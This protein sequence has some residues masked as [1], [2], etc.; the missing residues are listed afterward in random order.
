MKNI[1]LVVLLV[2]GSLVVGAAP[3]TF[4]AEAAK[5]EKEIRGVVK[6]GCAK[7]MFKMKDVDEHALAVKIDGKPYL[8]SGEF[9]DPVK[10]GLCKEIKDAQVV[11]RLIHYPAGAKVNGQDGEF[12]AESFTLK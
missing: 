3:Q 8:V 11:G 7:C 12:I 4:A 2:I 5:K 9:A 10:T 6:A 1:A